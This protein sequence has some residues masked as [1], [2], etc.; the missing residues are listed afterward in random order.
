MTDYSK[1]PTFTQY[2]LNVVSTL[3]PNLRTIVATTCCP[4]IVVWSDFNFG[5]QIEH[6]IGK[7]LEQ[8]QDNTGTRFTQHCGNIYTK[9]HGRPDNIAGM[10]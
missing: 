7:T 8:I 10:L 2:C 9:L 4:N 1:K 5:K 3:V 6:N